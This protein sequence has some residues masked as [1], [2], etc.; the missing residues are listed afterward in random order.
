[1]ASPHNLGWRQSYITAPLQLE[2]KTTI[3]YQLSV[4][5]TTLHWNQNLTMNQNCGFWPSTEINKTVT[6]DSALSEMDSLL[7]IKWGQGKFELD[8]L[9][10]LFQFL[11]PLIYECIPKEKVPKQTKSV[12]KSIQFT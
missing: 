3:K 10:K 7:T 8:N 6:L 1:M 11:N 12:S 9:Q 4:L 5:R 2:V